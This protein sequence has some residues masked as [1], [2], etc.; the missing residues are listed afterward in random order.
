ML[1]LLLALLCFATCRQA[2]AQAVFAQSFD[3]GALA[4]WLETVPAG[5]TLEPAAA[6]GACLLLAPAVKSATL[7]P[8][9]V[10]GGQK[11]RLSYR[12]RIEGEQT[13]EHNDRLHIEM[14]SSNGLLLP[15]CEMEF[16]DAAGEQVKGRGYQPG[17]AILTGEWYAYSHVFWAP[18][19]AT[20]LRVRFLPRQRALRVDDLELV[21]DDEGQAVNCNPDFRY[22]E[23][24]YCG[25]RPARDG[26]LYT[27][28]DGKT[29]LHSGYAGTSPRFPL[30]A[31][32]TY[33]LQARGTGTTANG[34]LS[35]TYYDAEGKSLGNRF[36]LRPVPAGSAVELTPPPGS[37]HG[38][39]AMYS[40]ILEEFRVTELPRP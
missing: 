5:A 12:A 31:G 16:L 40:V 21:A 7:K 13:V 6:G 36:L 2:M 28:P 32:A 18:A 35:L 19:G 8:I 15:A 23:L 39:V 24:N 26:R 22:G 3:N 37:D 17:G 25:W 20:A 4:E 14:L 1:R 10:T 33:R 27:R 9:A 30:R 29:V 11:L 34:W 38:T